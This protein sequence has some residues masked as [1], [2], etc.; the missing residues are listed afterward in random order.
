M[1]PYAS[2]IVIAADSRVSDETLAGYDA[3]AD[4]LFRI[5]YVLPERH[6]AWLCAQCEGD[7]ILRL[8]GDEV[9]SQALVKR[10]PEML[11][12]RGVRQYWIRRAWVHPDAASVLAA[13]PWSEDFVNRLMRNDGT[14]RISGQTHSQPEPVT[15][16]EYIEEPIYHLDL[17]VS[18]HRQRL[19][20]IVRYEASRSR[21]LAAG[22]GRLNEAFYLPE[23]RRE[24]PKLYPV[25]EE[26]RAAIVCALEGSLE[27]AKV[28]SSQSVPLVSLEEMDRMW[29]GRRVGANAYRASIALREPT[30][31]LAPSE[32]RQ[33]MVRICNE[34]D[35]RWPANVDEEPR[36][37][38]SYRL[39]NPDGSM[40]TPEGPRSA[41][42]RVVRP[43]DQILA[44]LHIDAPTQSGEYV[45][46]IDVVHEEERWFGCACRVPLRVEHPPGLP[47]AEG[48]LR[49]TNP[50]RFR[51]WRAMRI[52]PT[53]HRIWL[54]EEPL[55]EEHE[56]FGRT[57]AQYHPDWE[58]RL[59][60]DDHL[61]ELGIGA[62]ER[63]RARTKAELANLARYE[64]LHRY[65]GVYVDTDVECKRCLVPLLRGI[66]AFAALEVSGAIGNAILGSIAKHPVYA[67]ATRLA[68]QTL[69]TGVHSPDATGPRFLS[70]IIEQ[71]QNVAIFAAKLFYPYLWDELERRHDVFP[72]AYAV[73]HWTLSWVEKSASG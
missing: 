12:A 11:A 63:E 53:I 28:A 51:R 41:F 62:P 61:S 47:P 17:L 6:L 25:P 19:D 30:V 33:V 70:L 44:P 68:R 37:R 32:R 67:H 66:D 23:A 52:P 24:A 45:L 8:D 9:P 49:E 36:I 55:P 59:W 64:V 2:E 29:E 48:R 22:G 38:L 72:H 43:G 39:L 14:L 54:G 31:A 56:R 7:W 4:K 73:H 60:T 46:E 71:E 65:G 26:D 21:L 16:R 1:R 15:P 5:E 10:L 34:G 42:P 40:H 50:P 3:I 57:F 58:M 69:G 20:K 27:P 18:S 13:M 35:E